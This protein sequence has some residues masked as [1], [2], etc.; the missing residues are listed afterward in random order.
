MGCLQKANRR[1]GL[2]DSRR[3]R[4]ADRA[5]RSGRR[6]VPPSS[7]LNRGSTT[8]SLHAGSRTTAA[9]MITRRMTASS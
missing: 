1:G 8:H 6:T 5:Q 3:R 9:M 2:Y 7:R 4:D